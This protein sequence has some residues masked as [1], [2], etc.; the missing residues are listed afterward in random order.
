ME[1]AKP[2]NLDQ[3]QQISKHSVT[4]ESDAD[5]IIGPLYHY[6][7]VRYNPPNGNVDTF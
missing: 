7:S 1:K 4:S 2:A 5:I 6:V 3:S